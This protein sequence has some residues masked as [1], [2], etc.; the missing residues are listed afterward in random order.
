MSVIGWV[1]LILV[2]SQGIVGYTFSTQ[3]ECLEAKEELARAEDV[4]ALGS[5]VTD[6]ITEVERGQRL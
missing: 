2:Q 3:E 5:C 1:L 6:K 4:L